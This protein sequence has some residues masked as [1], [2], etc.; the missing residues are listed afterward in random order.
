MTMLPDPESEP[1]ISVEDAGRAM[2]LGRTLAYQEARRY[3]ATGGA[4]GLPAIRFGRTLRCPTA[5]LRRMVGLE[6]GRDGAPAEAGAR[7]TSIGLVDTEGVD[8]GR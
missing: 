6:P 2:G 7:H 1:T 8:H 4:E 5:E 3:I